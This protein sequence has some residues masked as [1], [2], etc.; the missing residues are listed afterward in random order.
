METKII[1]QSLNRQEALEAMNLTL[2]RFSALMNNVSTDPRSRLYD[3]KLTRIIYKLD[4]QN[5]YLKVN[6]FFLS[7][8]YNRLSSDG[9]RD[10][11]LKMREL[12]QKFCLKVEI[13]QDIN[14]IAEN[15]IEDFISEL[16]QLS[17]NVLE[18]NKTEL[19]PCWD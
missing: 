12:S 10:L 8:E 16:T 5:Y 19:L 9:I 2:T 17:L 1:Q 7:G 15:V 6:Q 3:E 13:P 18:K 11:L 14:V 4:N